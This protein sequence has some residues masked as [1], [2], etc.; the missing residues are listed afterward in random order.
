[1]LVDVSATSPA[2]W[3]YVSEGGSSIVFSYAGPASPYFS[4]TALRLR[5]S[6]ITGGDVEVPHLDDTPQ[7]E[8]PD[9]PTVVFQQ[10][11]TSRLIPAEYLPR[12]LCVRVTEPW[13][14]QLHDLSNEQRPEARRS[15]DAITVKKTKA[16]LADDLVG[17]E[18]FV[19]E[20]K[21][22]PVSLSCLYYHTHAMLAKVGI[23]ILAYTSFS[24]Q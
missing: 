9:D 13:L 1:M 5:K 21:V 19:I 10:K 8:E 24:S 3:K 4:G 23:Y 6:P 20:I 15:K 12:L 11:V 18:G 17:G 14:Q 16:V 22:L 2:D 7:D